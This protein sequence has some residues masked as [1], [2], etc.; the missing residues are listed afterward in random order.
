MNMHNPRGGG[1]ELGAQ[2]RTER[3][4]AK[5][6][7]MATI[8]LHLHNAGS[9]RR[10]PWRNERRLAEAT[11]LNPEVC[12]SHINPRPLFLRRGKA[13][14]HPVQTAPF[15]YRSRSGSHYAYRVHSAIRSADTTLSVWTAMIWIRPDPSRPPR[16]QPLAAVSPANQ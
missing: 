10:K 13:N 11:T 15:H 4:E 14:T 1:Q 6:R 3:V 8:N 16:D 12:L 5:V 2:S 9:C 7:R